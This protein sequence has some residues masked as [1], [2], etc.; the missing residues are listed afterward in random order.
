M[1]KSQVLPAAATYGQI[2]ELLGGHLLHNGCD[3]ESDFSGS[4]AH[5]HS[6]LPGLFSRMADRQDFRRNAYH[7]IDKDEA[8]SLF[9]CTA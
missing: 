5:T 2:Y 1:S 9:G 8:W 7:K 3:H 4:P 6:L